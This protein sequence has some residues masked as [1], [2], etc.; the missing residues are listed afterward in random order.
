VRSNA[1]VQ[2]ELCASQLHASP[3]SPTLPVVRHRLL[4]VTILLACAAAACGPSFQAVYEGD[5]HFEHCYAL[6]QSASALPTKQGCWREWLHEYT[7]G[8]SRDRVEYAAARFSELSLN[9]ALPGD[10]AVPELR[11]GLRTADAPMPTSAFVPPPNVVDGHAAPDAGVSATASPVDPP[12]DAAVRAPGAE[13][14]AACEPRWT[15]CRATCKEGACAACDHAYRTCV[16]AC[17][18]DGP[19]PRRP[20]ASSSR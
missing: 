10:A 15:S 12:H 9:P 6:D 14:A 11:A 17:F 18:Q 8:Q 3:A 20:P 19:A 7:Y 13:C 2:V 16:P 4:P 5:V 1:G